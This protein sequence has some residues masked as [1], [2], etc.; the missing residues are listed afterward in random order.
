MTG[1]NHWNNCYSFIS[2][3]ILVNFLSYYYRG[4][5][6][7]KPPKQTKDEEMARKLWEVSEE[8]VYLDSNNPFIEG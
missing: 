7:A 2:Y 1:W 8:M 4:C 6:V 5:A 3:H